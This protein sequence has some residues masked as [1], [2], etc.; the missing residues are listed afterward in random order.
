MTGPVIIKKVKSFYD[1]MKITNTYPFS[2]GWLL[3]FKEPAGE[4]DAQME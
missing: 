4:V 1:E 3:N 2:E